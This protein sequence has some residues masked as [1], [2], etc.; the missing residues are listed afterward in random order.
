MSQD[1]RIEQ[2]P[3]GA[4]RFG[5]AALTEWTAIVEQVMRGV[6]HALNNRA[7]ALSAVIELAHGATPDDVAATQSILGTELTRVG[8]LGQVLR[9]LGPAGAGDQAFAPGDAIPEIRSILELQAERREW[10]VHVDDAGAPPVRVAR[11]M[12]VRAVVSL[13]VVAAGAAARDAKTPVRITLD[14]DGQDWVAVR[15]SGTRHA[16]ALS[17]YALE[18]AAAM[19]GEPLAADQRGFRVPSLAAIRRREAR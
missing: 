11:W 10:T 9:A 4:P 16:A 8:E 18:L 13:G 14:A 5:A 2:T 12:F 1:T 7:A 3:S 17:R 15:L 6:A 19:G